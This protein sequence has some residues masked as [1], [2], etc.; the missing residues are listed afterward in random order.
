MS[1]IQTSAANRPQLDRI[2]RDSA[3]QATAMRGGAGGA[4][5]SAWTS[6]LRRAARNENPA[7]RAFGGADDGAR[8]HDVLHGKGNGRPDDTR[9][10]RREPARLRGIPG[11]A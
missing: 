10:Y 2:W 9:P 8:I 3:R 5:K 4:C 1:V 11:S 6:F 7:Q